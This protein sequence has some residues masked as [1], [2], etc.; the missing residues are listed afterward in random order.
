MKGKLKPDS[1]YAFISIISLLYVQYYQATLYYH[2]TPYSVL[3]ILY[4]NIAVPSFYFFTAAFIFT[5]ILNFFTFTIHKPLRN[6]LLI[7]VSLA[8]LLYIALV[9]A[10]IIPIFVFT[11]IYLLGFSAAGLLF[12]LAL[13]KK[14]DT[15]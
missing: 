6:I 13:H 12:A 7:I 5:V 11:S 3:D 4:L 10:K 15:I 1:V 9:I 8:L 2:V 14:K